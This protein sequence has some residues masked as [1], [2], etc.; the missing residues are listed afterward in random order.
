MYAA[1]Y[2]FEPV[3]TKL[4]AEDLEG[5]LSSLYGEPSKTASN[6]DIWG[7]VVNY[8]YWYGANDTLLVL[9][10][11]DKSGSTWKSDEEIRI[12]YAWREGDRLLQEASDCLEREAIASEKSKFGNGNTNGL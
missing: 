10:V 7:G 11:D 8:T 6:T 5:K 1:S 9:C 3:N 2:E 4:M 12:V